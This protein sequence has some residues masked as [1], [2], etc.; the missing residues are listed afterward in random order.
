MEAALKIF[1]DFDGVLRRESSPKSKL[2]PDC[3][4]HFEQAVMSHPHARVVI[5][6]T[7][8]LVHRID[9]LRKLFSPAFAARVEGVTP[10]LPE[11][12]EYVRH[13]EI[14]AYLTRNRLHGMR[15]IAVDDDPEGYKSDAP[16]IQVDPARGFNEDCASRLRSWLG[17]R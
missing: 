9:A 16:L 8:R 3:V 4:Q 6:S 14:N 12:E 5:V 10:D 13:A 15:W 17:G 1:V 7:W 11:V 2:D